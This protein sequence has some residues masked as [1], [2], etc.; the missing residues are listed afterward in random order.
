M[1]SS[2]DVRCEQPPPFRRVVGPEDPP[3]AAVISLDQAPRRG[4]VDDPIDH[5]WCR[6]LPAIRIE[7]GEPDEAEA[8]G[9]ANV[10]SPERTVALFAVSSSVG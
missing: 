7:V 6:F 9:A 4:D 1:E 10:D 2:L 3:S 8:L 5:E